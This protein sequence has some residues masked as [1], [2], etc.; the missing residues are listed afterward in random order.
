MIAFFGA[1]FGACTALLIAAPVV[2]IGYGITLLA[3]SWRDGR[4]VIAQ[5]RARH[6]A[7]VEAYI[8]GDAAWLR[9]LSA[10]ELSDEDIAYLR[11]HGISEG[12]HQ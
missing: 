7:E 12:E 9:G 11:G 1:L 4:D 6:A 8:A 5:T 10:T 2:L 3:R